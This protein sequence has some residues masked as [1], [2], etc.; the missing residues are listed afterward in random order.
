MGKAASGGSG[1]R[2][3]GWCLGSARVFAFIHLQVF[4]TL[5]PCFKF[6]FSEAHSGYPSLLPN[7]FPLEPRN[8]HLHFISPWFFFCLLIYL[9]LCSQEETPWGQSFRACVVQCCVPSREWGQSACI[10]QVL[11]NTRVGVNWH[12][13]ILRALCS[14]HCLSMFVFGE[15]KIII[16]LLSAVVWRTTGW[17]LGNVGPILVT[18]ERETEE[19]ECLHILFFFF[20]LI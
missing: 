18:E 9:A 4:F 10:S 2:R 19:D 16:Y 7:A 5:G 6:T 3:A 14:V 20:C 15:W 1:G 11:V 8:S 12:G 13:D 17:S